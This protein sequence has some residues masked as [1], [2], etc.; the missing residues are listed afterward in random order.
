[1]R[2]PALLLCMLLG[3]LAEEHARHGTPTKEFEARHSEGGHNPDLD[4]QAVL[5]SRRTAAEFDSLS[6]EE[7]RR[8]LRVL[9]Q[10]VDVDGD[11]VVTPAELEAWV[12]RSLLSLDEE[13]TKERFEEIDQGEF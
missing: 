7:S 9:A 1:M 3:V 10:R 11:G 2:L 6:P 5:G 4:H 8:R 13:E 12:Y